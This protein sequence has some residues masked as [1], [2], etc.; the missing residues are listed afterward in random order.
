MYTCSIDP[1][2]IMNYPKLRI[3]PNL[4]LALFLLEF[5]CEIFLF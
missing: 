3:L 4:I 1:S 2:I 5:T